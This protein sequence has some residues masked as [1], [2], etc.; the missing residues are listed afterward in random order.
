M[1]DKYGVPLYK[2]HMVEH[3]LDQIRPPNK[4]LKTEFNICRSPHFS[5]PARLSTYLPMV[6]ARL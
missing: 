4:K 5:T 1:L 2:D 3:L 6:V